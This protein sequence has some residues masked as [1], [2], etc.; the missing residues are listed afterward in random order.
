MQNLKV[1]L[2]SRPKEGK[3]VKRPKNAADTRIGLPLPERN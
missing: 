2:P 3:R 1:L